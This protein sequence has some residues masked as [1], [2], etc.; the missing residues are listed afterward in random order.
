MEAEIAY[1]QK[2]IERQKE[3]AADSE[4]RIFQ[5]RRELGMISRN[6]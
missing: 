2:D 1:M 4:E 3:K 6:D 5:L